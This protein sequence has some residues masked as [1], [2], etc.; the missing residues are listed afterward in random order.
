MRHT[1][2][3][4][5]SKLAWLPAQQVDLPELTYARLNGPRASL[6]QRGARL[7]L[8][9]AR[10]SPDV[11]NVAGLQILASENMRRKI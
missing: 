1:A 8:L 11:L 6:H 2:A 7:V 4:N 9:G 10:T 3:A 5:V